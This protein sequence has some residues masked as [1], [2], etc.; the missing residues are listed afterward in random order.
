[1]N[2]ARPRPRAP[3]RE[4]TAALE[5]ARRDRKRSQDDRVQ[6]DGW[7]QEKDR[8]PPV[9]GRYSQSSKVDVR[10]SK[11]LR[12]STFEL[13]TYLPWPV[14]AASADEFAAQARLQQRLRLSPARPAPRSLDR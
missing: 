6:R 10:R 14:T 7:N 1:E 12:S 5:Q 13:L 2:E 8:P 9:V 11:L 3:V 4:P